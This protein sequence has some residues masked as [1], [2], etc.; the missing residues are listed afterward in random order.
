MERT[1]PE[2]PV[3]RRVS[4]GGSAST[5][6]LNHLP[7]LSFQLCDKTQPCFLDGG[8]GKFTA[9]ARILFQKLIQC[10]APFQIVNQDF[11]RNASSAEDRLSTENVRV[12]DDCIFRDSSHGDPPARILIIS[13]IRKDCPRKVQIA[14]HELYS[15]PA[16]AKTSVCGTQNRLGFYRLCPRPWMK[17]CR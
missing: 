4:T 3:W 10:V 6:D 12:L 14:R 9:D 7:G 5:A 8:N 1:H 16:N 2:A 17:I 11:E 13:P 15:K